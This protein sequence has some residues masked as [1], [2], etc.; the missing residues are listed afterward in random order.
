MV[1]DNRRPLAVMKNPVNIPVHVN[2]MTE[3]KISLE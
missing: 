2:K 1:P 3:K